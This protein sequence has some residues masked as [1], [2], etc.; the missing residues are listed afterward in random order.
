MKSED[1]SFKLKWKHEALIQ[2]IYSFL[3]SILSLLQV[4]MSYITQHYTIL[5]SKG[6]TTHLL[7]R[8]ARVI[9]DI[10]C[11]FKTLELAG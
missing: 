8:I 6:V 4:S 3:I 2:I 7:G 5:M 10:V 1:F 11:L 9:F